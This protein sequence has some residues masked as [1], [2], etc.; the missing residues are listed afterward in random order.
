MS[1][2][3]LVKLYLSMSNCSEFVVEPIVGLFKT[4]EMHLS[5]LF[6][7]VQVLYK[8]VVLRKSGLSCLKIGLCLLEGFLELNTMLH[9]FF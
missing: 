7:L 1:V 4:S 5:S 9:S 3:N 8:L 2:L 6:V